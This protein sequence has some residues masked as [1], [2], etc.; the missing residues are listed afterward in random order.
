MEL[1][2]DGDD[3]DVPDEDAPGDD[4]VAATTP[5]NTKTAMDAVA[6]VADQ[7]SEFFVLA[8][9]AAV[10]GALALNALGYGFAAQPE[11]GVRFDAIEQLR[12]ERQMAQSVTAPGIYATK[13]ANPVMNFWRKN[14]LIVTF[15]LTGAILAVEEI[16]ARKDT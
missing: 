9:G 15:V 12:T 3:A 6:A 7:A 16:R 14:P 10:A 13:E 2:A 5:A 11:G 1:A 8:A 4:E